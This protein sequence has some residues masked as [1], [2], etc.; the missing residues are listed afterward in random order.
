MG[1][2]DAVFGVPVF[3]IRIVSNPFGCPQIATRQPWIDGD[4][5]SPGE[6]SDWLHQ[7]GFSSVPRSLHDR[8]S[9][10][11]GSA[12]F[13]PADNVLMGDAVARNFLKTPDGIIVPI[14]VSLTLLPEDRLPDEAWSG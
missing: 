13:R 5:P 8:A 4:I 12:W 3:V 6:L 11:A 7:Q 2:M 9:V 1:L 10:P 14:D